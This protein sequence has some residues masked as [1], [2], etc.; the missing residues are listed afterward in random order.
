MK[1]SGF[2]AIISRLFILFTFP[3]VFKYRVA[4]FYSRLPPPSQ[5][6]GGIAAV[7]GNR[8]LQLGLAG[9]RHGIERSF[10]ELGFNSYV[11]T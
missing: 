8:A 2:C 11:F 6:G 10:R 3:F 5:V 4:L 7:V 9:E 1:T